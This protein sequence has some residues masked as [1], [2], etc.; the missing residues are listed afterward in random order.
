[1]ASDS[2]AVVVVSLRINQ[3]SQA[4]WVETQLYNAYIYQFNQNMPW[5]VLFGCINYRPLLI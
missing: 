2:I 5:L 3:R 1:M 4:S